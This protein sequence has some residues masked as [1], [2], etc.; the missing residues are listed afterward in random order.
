[1]IDRDRI[2]PKLQGQGM[3]DA[4]MMPS[5]CGEPDFATINAPDFRCGARLRLND[6]GATLS[7][8]LTEECDFPDEGGVEDE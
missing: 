8:A 5:G 3:L 1:M 7:I 6:H 4:P 2:V